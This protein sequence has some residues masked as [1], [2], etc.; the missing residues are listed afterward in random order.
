[1]SLAGD[2]GGVF[3]IMTLAHFVNDW[4]PQTEND[5]KMKQHDW[6][7]RALH[8]NA[9]SWLT[10]FS[11]LAVVHKWSLSLGLLAYA[12]LFI[13]HFA[14]DTYWLPLWWMERVRK[15][16]KGVYEGFNLVLVVVIDQCV[17]LACLLLACYAAVLW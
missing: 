7:V 6:R 8:C 9:Y 12:W 11:L 17:H 16:S 10:A 4:I 13:T 3:A 2:V 5:A 15:P 14:E 1:M